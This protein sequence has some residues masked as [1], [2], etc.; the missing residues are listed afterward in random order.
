[1]KYFPLVSDDFSHS[2]GVRALGEGERLVETTSQYRS[3]IVLKRKLLDAH[4]EWYLAADDDTKAAQQEAFDY[5]LQWSAHLESCRNT[6]LQETI[7][8]GEQPLLSIARHL[9]EDLVLLAN[10]ASRDCPVV[11]GAVCF[12][13]GWSLRDKMGQGMMSVHAAVPEFAAKLLIPTQQLLARLKVGRPV[14]R[15]NW[16]VRPS[17]QLDQS[18]RHAASLLERARAVT[19]SNAGLTCF[20]R[21][22]R[23]TLSRLPTTDHIL[24]TIH[25]HQCALSELTRPQQQRLCKVLQSCPASTLRYKGLSEIVAPVTR[26]LQSNQDRSA[27]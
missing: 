22:E 27:Q 23:Q 9:Q 19:S 11:A 18:P 13:S 15:M 5:L 2:L 17:N 24:F 25:T 26:F 16:G 1:M 21:V 6:L 4:P 10:D 8:A 14:W 3:E 7:E 20:L 12:P